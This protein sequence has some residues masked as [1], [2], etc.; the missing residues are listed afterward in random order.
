MSSLP[1]AQGRRK[2]REEKRIKE[3]EEKDVRFNVSILSSFLSPSCPLPPTKEEGKRGETWEKE[4][5]KGGS[6]GWFLAL[7]FLAFLYTRSS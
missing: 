2:K 1:I 3:G 4:E 6:N 5:G 7:P